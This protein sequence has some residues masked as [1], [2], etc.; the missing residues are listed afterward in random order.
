MKGPDERNPS[1]NH[2]DSTF[3]TPWWNAIGG[4]VGQQA[5]V[6]HVLLVKTTN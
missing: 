3:W 6:K 5:S 4:P 2:G 1:L